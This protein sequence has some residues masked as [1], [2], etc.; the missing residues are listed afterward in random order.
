MRV[1][2]VALILYL[3]KTIKIPLFVV[4]KR[5][6]MITTIIVDYLYSGKLPTRELLISSFLVLAGGIVAGYD[7]LD[8]DLWEYALIV[9]SCFSTSLISVVTYVYNDKGVLNVFDLNFFYAVIG[10]P[11]SY[12]VTSYNGEFAKIYSVLSGGEFLGSMPPPKMKMY[13]IISGGLG[14]WINMFALLCVT[15]NGPISI[16]LTSVFKDFGLTYV[17]YLIFSD[18]KVTPAGLLGIALSFFGASYYLWTKYVES[19]AAKAK[20]VK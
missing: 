9:S 6:S 3:L 2:D 13:M 10:L 11:F 5:C 19:E 8:G 18:D 20:K 7:T 14:I 17:G 16:N 1:A 4:I 12:I 15:I